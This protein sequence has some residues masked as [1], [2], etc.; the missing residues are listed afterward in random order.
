MTEQVGDPAVDPNPDPAADPNPE[1]KPDPPA[2]TFSQEALNGLLAKQKRE[3]LGDASDVAELRKK[4]LAF[5]ELQQASKTE[6]E[7]EREARTAAEQRAEQIEAEVKE[8]RLRSAII[9]EAAKPARKIVDPD[10]VVALLDRSTLEFDEAG[11]PTNVAQALD[12]LLE[13]R[14]YLVASSGGSRG[15]ADQGARPGTAAGQLTQEDLQ[16]MSSAEIVKAQADGR[17]DALLGAT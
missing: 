6:L 15:N 10:A 16:R 4:A 5:D 8:T 9:S 7:R 13:T 14:P 12:L 11:S 2:R 17:L 3:L 1:P